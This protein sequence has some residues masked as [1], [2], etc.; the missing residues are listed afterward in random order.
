MIPPLTNDE[1]KKVDDW[2]KANHLKCAH[3]YTGA[4]GGFIEYYAIPTGLGTIYGVRCLVCKKNPIDLTA[5]NE[6]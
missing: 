1:H 3:T 2:I 6:W 4:I 5:Y